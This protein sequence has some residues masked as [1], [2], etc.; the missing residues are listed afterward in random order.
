MC[1]EIEYKNKQTNEPKSR[2]IFLCVS[3]VNIKSQSLGVKKSQKNQSTGFY[4]LAINFILFVFP[5]RDNS[6]ISRFVCVVCVK[7]VCEKKVL[8]HE[9][10]EIK[11]KMGKTTQEKYFF[12]AVVWLEKNFVRT[13]TDRQQ[14]QVDYIFRLN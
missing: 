2:A 14:A 3:V 7:T 11:E 9:N 1:H 5:V 12:V 13:E 10:I 4:Q 8:E 6:F